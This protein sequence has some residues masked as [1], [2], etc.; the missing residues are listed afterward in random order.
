MTS[1]SDETRNFF[2]RTNGS[3]RTWAILRSNILYN[4]IAF[5]TIVMCSAVVTALPPQTF[6]NRTSC[7]RSLTVPAWGYLTRCL[8]TA[9]SHLLYFAL[10][11]TVVIAAYSAPECFHSVLDTKAVTHAFFLSKHTCCFHTEGTQST[12][13]HLQPFII[14]LSPFSVISAPIR[15]TFAMWCVV[16]GVHV[17]RYIGTGVGQDFNCNA[18]PIFV[19]LLTVLRIVSLR[20]S[21]EL[22]HSWFPPTPLHTPPTQCTHVYKRP[23]FS[24]RSIVSESK[25]FPSLFCF[26]YESHH[27]YERGW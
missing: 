7:S 26:S 2:V 4:C 5:D 11:E 15:T 12:Y 22:C 8:P 25:C 19:C 14:T 3:V 20:F 16:Y 24:A 18:L 17:M 27:R 6:H 10:H 21:R 9:H 13:C 23:F 1:C